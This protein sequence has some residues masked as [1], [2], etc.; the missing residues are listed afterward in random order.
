MNVID[1]DSM[2]IQIQSQHELEF[3]IN[4][5]LMQS[6]KHDAT[7]TAILRQLCS[8]RKIDPVDPEWLVLLDELD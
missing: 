3:L 6:R 4:A 2:V 5:V 8:L 1:N 7:A